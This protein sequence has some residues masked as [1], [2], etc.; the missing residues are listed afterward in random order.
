MRSQLQRVKETNYCADLETKFF[1]TIFL[2][3]TNY[4]YPPDGGR[5]TDAEVFGVQLRPL[6]QPRVPEEGVEGPQERVQGGEV[7]PA[8]N[9]RRQNPA[10]GKDPVEETEGGARAARENK[11]LLNCCENFLSHIF[12]NG[13]NIFKH[14]V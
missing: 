5:A 10:G 9:P 11:C 13:L 3:K 7:R 4:F 12:E 14:I 1:N 6:L 2:G 8:G